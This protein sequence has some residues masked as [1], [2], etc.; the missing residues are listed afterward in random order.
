[1]TQDLYRPSNSSEGCGFYAEWC[2]NCARDKPMSEGKDYDECGP[3]E[4]CEIIA[5]TLAYDV[6]DPR[7]PKAWTYK[8][9]QPCC[10]EFIQAG[11]EIRHRCAHTPDMFDPAAS[12]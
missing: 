11:Q 12:T 4:V 8:D 3:E 1:M 5:H 10:T 2:A 9:G 6:T 7:Y